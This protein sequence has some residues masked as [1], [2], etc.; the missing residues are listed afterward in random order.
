MTTLVYVFSRRSLVNGRYVMDISQAYQ[1]AFTDINEQMDAEI[2]GLPLLVVECEVDTP[3]RV[4]IQADANFPVIFWR[5]T[6]A[7][8]AIIAGNETNV[9]TLTQA[10]AFIAWMT[11]ASRWP[12]LSQRKK[13][14]ILSCVGQTRKRAGIT[15][16]R[17]MRRMLSED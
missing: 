17:A 10:N 2:P 1:G 8:R 16:V 15:L 9:V 14:V 11:N 3:T 13:D 4:A 6:D 5:E 12:N 7:N